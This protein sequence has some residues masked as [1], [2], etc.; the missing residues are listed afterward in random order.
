MMK[1]RIVFAT[2]LKGVNRVLKVKNQKW[3][4]NHK[5]ALKTIMK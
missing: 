4:I 3:I 2:K 1:T 5:A